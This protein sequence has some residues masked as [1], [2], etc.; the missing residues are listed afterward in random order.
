MASESAK[1]L[2]RRHRAARKIANGDGDAYMSLKTYAAMQSK[3]AGGAAGD[4]RL[5]SSV[6]IWLAHKRPQTAKRRGA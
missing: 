4:S 5:W 6:R 1:Y 3:A 2:R